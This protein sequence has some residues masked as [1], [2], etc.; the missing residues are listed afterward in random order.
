MAAAKLRLLRVF[1][2]QLV[3]NIVK[4]LHVALLWV[5]LERGD[6]RVRHGTSGLPSDVRILSVRMVL[7]VYGSSKSDGMTAAQFCINSANVTRRPDAKEQ[8]PGLS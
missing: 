7:L 2:L 3:S 5:L 4:E 6:K 8:P 1:A